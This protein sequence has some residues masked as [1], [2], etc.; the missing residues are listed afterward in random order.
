MRWQKLG[1][2]WWRWGSPGVGTEGEPELRVLGTKG[3]TAAWT[4][5]GAKGKPAKFSVGSGG[6]GVG[7]EGEPELR[8]LGAEG[9]PT[10]WTVECG[11]CRGQTSQVVQ[12]L[13]R[14][15]LAPIVNQSSTQQGKEAEKNSALSTGEP[16]FLFFLALVTI[17]EMT[18]LLQKLFAVFG[19]TAVAATS[20]VV[21]TAP[22][23]VEVVAAPEAA[24]VAATTT[25]DVGCSSM[26]CR[27]CVGVVN[28]HADTVL[29]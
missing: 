16:A 24:T 9:E 23:A 25:A 20:A 14:L 12:E 27:H 4:V 19:V 15:E 1:P 28:D 18:G 26:S 10:A 17:G 11:W 5:D 21:G 6:G 7:T 8:V 29:E 3:K 22:T 2:G 13:E